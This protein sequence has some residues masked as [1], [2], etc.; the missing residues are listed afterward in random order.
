MSRGQGGQPDGARAASPVE[1][2]VAN[3]AFFIV[4]TSDRTTGWTAAHRARWSACG[5]SV[6][7]Y[8]HL[9][10]RCL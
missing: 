2:I 9:V 3:V 7:M 6:M 4:D 10:R 8:L 5:D 1:T